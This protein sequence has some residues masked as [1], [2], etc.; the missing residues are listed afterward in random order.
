VLAAWNE[1]GGAKAGKFD[2]RKTLG[3]AKLGGYRADEN[4]N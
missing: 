4:A 2:Q 3:I 1:G